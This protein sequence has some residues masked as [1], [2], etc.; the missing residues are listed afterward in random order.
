[1]T[2]KDAAETLQKIIRQLENANILVKKIEDEM[3]DISTQ[4][5]T[6]SMTNFSEYQ[7]NCGLI[8]NGF[9]AIITLLVDEDKKQCDCEDDY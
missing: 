7:R 2:K 5:T 9:S 4:Y 8:S 6:T 1:M 3:Q